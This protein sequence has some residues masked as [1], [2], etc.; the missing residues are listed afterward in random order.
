[1]INK[2]ILFLDH[3]SVPG[4]SSISLCELVKKINPDHYKTIVSCNSPRLFEFYN[5]EDITTDYCGL[6]MFHHTTASWWTISIKSMKSFFMW[7]FKFLKSRSRLKQL[8]K[9]HDPEIVHLNSITLAPYLKLLKSWNVFTV[10]H[11]RE[12]VVDGYLGLRKKCIKRTIEK[13]A[14]RAIFICEHNKNALSTQKGEVIYNPVNL[15]K[16]KRKDYLTIKEKLGLKANQ[17]IVLYV[18]GLRIING[19]LVFVKCLR[20]IIEKYPDVK[21][22]MPYT[23]YSP[24]ITLLSNVK[25]YLGNCVNYYSP[26]QLIEIEINRHDLKNNILQFDFIN[27]IES[28]FVASDIVV[29]PFISP[30]FARAVIEAGAAAKPVVAS[31]IGGI[32]EV[33]KHEVNG[34]LSAPGN[35][36]ELTYNILRCLKDDSMSK[37]MGSNGLR[38]AKNH[39]DANM[40]V[41]KL[42]KVYDSL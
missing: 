33:V 21:I 12:T 35:T 40:H 24:S 32:S 13:Y 38:L 9:K 19:P 1:L 7:R 39:F 18:G 26:R 28:F 36:K 14:D 8:I 4:G 31:N 37:D 41:K 42:T 17:K 2:K 25:R 34:L 30:H 22:L 16:F 27:E 3:S 5:N 11:I 20:D 23:S 15:D 10:I 29:V 6:E